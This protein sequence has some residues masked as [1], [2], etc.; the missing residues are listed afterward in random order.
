M[1]DLNELYGTVTTYAWTGEAGP[2]TAHGSYYIDPTN[3]NDGSDATYARRPPGAAL[4]P[5]GTWQWY[6]VSDLG[7][8]RSVGSMLFRGSN[9]FAPDAIAIIQSSNLAAPDTQAN[10]ETADWDDVAQTTTGSFGNAYGGWDATSEFDAPVVARWFRVGTYQYTASSLFFGEFDVRL[11]AINEAEACPVADFVGSPLI[12]PAPLEVAFTDE[13]TGDP[14]SWLWDFGDGETSTDQNPIHTFADPGTYEVT[15]TVSKDGCDDSTL[16][17]AS[18]IVASLDCRPMVLDV[19]KPNIGAPPL[20]SDMAFLET[21][22]T[23]KD[24]WAKV[25]ELGVGSGGFR[26][27][28]YSAEATE[29][30][31]GN[32]TT[33]VRFAKV[34]L[35]AVDAAPIH[36]FW[37]ETGLLELL[38]EAE[39]G[40]EDFV[41]AGRGTGAYLSFAR[42]ATRSYLDDASIAVAD[43]VDGVWYFERP[44]MATSLG[45]LASG[46][47]GTNALLSSWQLP[48][49]NPSGDE[50]LLVSFV[51][52]TGPETL[53]ATGWTNRAEEVTTEFATDFRYAMLD[54]YHA[55][56]AG[57]Y[58]DTFT[59]GAAARWTAAQVAFRATGGPSSPETASTHQAASTAADTIVATLSGTPTPGNV[60]LAY[61]TETSDG[62]GT[63]SYVLPTGW[64]LLQRIPN[65]NTYTG[66]AAVI[67]KLADGT[68]T[69]VEVTVKIA[70]GSLL[71]STT[72]LV[73]EYP[74]L[75]AP[76][77]AGQILYLVLAELMAATASGRPVH[78]LPLLSIDFT[79]ELD[80]NGDPWDATPATAQFTA[81]A[82][83][84]V[85]GVV[86]RLMQ[87]GALVL[88]WDI[89]GDAFLLHAYNRSSYGRNLTGSSFASDVV[90]LQSGASIVTSL[91]R[92][93]VAD[94]KATHAW[95]S[96]DADT[97]ALV[98]AAD[99]ATRVIREI[100]VRAQGVTD[101]A[102]LAGI[103]ADE[104]AVS[105]LRAEKL[106]S[107]VRIGN[108]PASGE[109]LP[110][111][112]WTANGHLWPGD[113]IT[114]DTGSGE[115]DY[116]DDSFRIAGVL[117]AEPKGDDAAVVLVTDLEVD[118]ELGSVMN[119][120]SLEAIIAG[121]SG[122]VPSASS[123][124]GTTGGVVPDLTAYQRLDEKSQPD[125][126][127]SLDGD[128]HV[129]AGE[130][131]SGATG[132]GS[133]V[134][135][136]DGTWGT[137]AIPLIVQEADS[138]V[139]A[140]VAALDFGNGFDVTE[141]P[142]GEANIVVDPSE[143]KLD[144]FGTPDDNT[145]LNASSSRHGLLRKLSNVATEFL[146]GTGAWS[147][148]AGSGGGSG[149]VAT[150]FVGCS[151]YHNTTSAAS[152]L[153]FN[154]ELYDTDGFHDPSTNNSRVTIPA[155]LGGKYLITFAALSSGS[156]E[157]RPRKNGAAPYIGPNTPNGAQIWTLSFVA[158]LAAGDYV[159]FVTTGGTWGHGSAYEAQ[160]QATFTKLDSG[161]VGSGVGA[162]VYKAA[163]QTVSAATEETL[164]FDTEEFDPDGFHSTSS[165]T[166]RFTIPAGLGGQYLVRA[167]VYHGGSPGSSYA[168]IR[169]NG[170]AA[171]N[172]S[173]DDNSASPHSLHP[174]GIY[175]LAA[176]DYIEVRSYRTS[177]TSSGNGTGG[178]AN[179]FSI[180]RLDSAA[181]LT[182]TLAS[183]KATRT[184]G[185]LTTTS[186]S[187]VDVTGMTVTLTT[188]ARRCL[189]AFQGTALNAST[190]RVAFD[191]LI[192][193]VSQ[194]GG[195]GVSQVSLAST[196]SADVGFSFLTD[197]L[198]AGSHTFKLQW[199]VSGG[200]GTL[201]AS[202][203]NM[204]ANLSVIE[205]PDTGAAS[206]TAMTAKGTWAG[207]ASAAT[208]AGSGVT[209]D[210][211][212][213]ARVVHPF[214]FTPTHMGVGI[215]TS[216]G[217]L[218]LGIYA[219]DGTGLAPGVKLCSTGNFSSPGTGRRT[220]AI[221]TPV[222]LPP[223]V[224]WYAAVGSTGS[225]STQ[226]TW[227]GTGNGGGG[228]MVC[229]YG[230]N[231]GTPGTLPATPVG[232]TANSW[233]MAV[234]SE[235]Q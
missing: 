128:G 135:L 186:A 143:L 42:M 130:L 122:G 88:D 39:E 182:E 55:T 142:A 156:F 36:G 65:R 166:G 198:A 177:G 155:G 82:G 174:G 190:E 12:G 71:T 54:R 154:A 172:G 159:E 202:T 34:R 203:T 11:W 137:A 21:L 87:T 106:T 105:A 118:A 165:N 26:I 49:L 51:Q 168:Y 121:G 161:Q 184:A 92:D 210:R 74:I 24:Q 56:A 44:D 103:G 222:Y 119:P 14:E 38:S 63:I 144:D 13:S 214:G 43:P 228:P 45:L 212:Y 110:G 68:E 59:S 129:P 78:P 77:K 201:Y 199:K 84:D 153:P 224:Y 50:V 164:L 167:N 95:V 229:M 181:P 220:R 233:A 158:D 116:D 48:A 227:T 69:D 32:G 7:V 57:P 208:S 86:L 25:E 97:Y 232:L 221:A 58:D 148:P 235:I 209:G 123:G 193:G 40:G 115:F 215:E 93:R 73:A 29:A 231:V 61:V 192:D 47:N 5:A 133:Q 225:L 3:V 101:G 85:L 20:D 136:D 9:G 178:A 62:P 150:G 22:C 117:I 138:T 157:V 140:S 70:G 139:V 204:P 16:V 234:W 171:L 89:T 64:T 160:I 66:V 226:Y 76:L 223:G 163:S 219:D 197:V 126:Y 102:A 99:A 94:R 107:R 152:P 15:L 120:D 149:G 194:G 2:R 124:S 23:A 127:A 72:L 132:T 96:G 134:L 151:I 90:R 169:K 180:M 108:A 10:P 83:E 4:G 125:G 80:S 162:A 173:E 111:P 183:G 175:D 205:I 100:G 195:L 104:L 31:L 191:L 27:N 230:S 147:E 141:S 218:D 1:T 196:E 19:Y 46:Q 145:D 114:V 170:S 6:L 211:P 98:T 187:F 206:G 79:Y 67:Y 91:K 217:S 28:R 185:D 112:E 17:R 35:P 60:L 200:T 179:W 8:A 30:I 81:L 216:A 188:G 75:Y 33:D 18:Y 213:Y 52:M 176:G 146:D 131:G 113:T 41:I 189:I 53:T 109:Y 37:L 207:V